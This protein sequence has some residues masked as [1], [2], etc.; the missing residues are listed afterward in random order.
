MPPALFNKEWVNPVCSFL[1][2]II[3]GVKR[4]PLLQ[5]SPAAGSALVFF[6]GKDSQS[7]QGLIK[8]LW[9]PKSKWFLWVLKV[10]TVTGAQLRNQSPSRDFLKSLHYSVCELCL[11]F[12]TVIKQQVQHMGKDFPELVPQFDILQ[13]SF[14]WLSRFS[15]WSSHGGEGAKKETRIVHPIASSPS[16]RPPGTSLTG[17]LHDLKDK[18]MYYIRD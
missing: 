4:C 1:D 9:A 18:L 15:L 10:S 7:Q 12:L 13:L 17:K 6:V 5:H 3:W 2:G 14:W 16:W 8:Q 11:L